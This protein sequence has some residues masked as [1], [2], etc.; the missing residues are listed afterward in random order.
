M[1]ASLFPYGLM[2]IMFTGAELFTGNVLV[3]LRSPIIPAADFDELLPDSLRLTSL[4]CLMGPSISLKWFAIYRWSILEISL[5]C[6]EFFYFLVMLR[7]CLVCVLWR[8]AR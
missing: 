6:F 4:A 1:G 7:L 3:T 5:V 8:M 2:L